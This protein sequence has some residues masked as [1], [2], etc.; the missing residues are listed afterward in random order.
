MKALAQHKETLEKILEL[1]K[2]QYPT[3]KI[4]FQ[5]LQYFDDRKPLVVVITIHHDDHDNAD[6]LR[7]YSL[8]TTIKQEQIL[9]PKI[10]AMEFEA[11]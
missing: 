3:D 6:R 2:K 7:Q 5:G 8:Y 1:L 11:K 10:V 4:I 9:I